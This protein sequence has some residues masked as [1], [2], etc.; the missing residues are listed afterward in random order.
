MS[1]LLDFEADDA[2]LDEAEVGATGGV[3]TYDAEVGA[4][5]V[6]EADD[7][8]LDDTAVGA[9]GYFEADEAAL[10]EAEV[11]ATGDDEADVGATCGGPVVGSRSF[12]DLLGRV[13]TE[14]H[15]P[16]DAVD[17][18]DNAAGRGMEPAGRD[19]PDDGVLDW[20]N[21][22]SG[23]GLVYDARIDRHGMESRAAQIREDQL[24]DMGTGPHGV[25]SAA[26]RDGIDG[27]T[28][29]AD[30]GAIVVSSG[31][32]S[33]M[34]RRSIDVGAGAAGS[35]RRIK[36]GGVNLA[37]RAAGR[38]GINA[39]AGA[40]GRGAIVVASTACAGLARVDG[41]GGID[42]RQGSR[43]E[44][45]AEF[46]RLRRTAIDGS[47]EQL[48]QQLDDTVDFIEC[49]AQCGFRANRNWR[50]F[51]GWCCGCCRL[52][53][54]SGSGRRHGVRC[55]LRPPLRRTAATAART[56][57]SRSRG[58]DREARSADE[59]YDEVD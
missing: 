46:R 12:S 53:Q 17:S 37:A 39:G 58:L 4:T 38:S 24:Q 3:E 7:A 41:R 18:G 9:T 11:G 26:G 19:G 52:R 31:A 48:A 25:D 6:V 33:S 36:Y 43:G 20:G 27:G 34:E 8:I 59:Q 28:G 35:R 50:A 30:R 14:L 49:V 16:W 45:G 23:A 56:A 51:S 57:R 2:A 55:T 54:M 1:A 10:D 21:Y 15:D 5:G 44:Q 47:A 22:A 42:G 32:G 29:S 13:G 40:V